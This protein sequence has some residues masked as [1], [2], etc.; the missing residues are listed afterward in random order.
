MQPFISQSFLTYL[1]SSFIIHLHTFHSGHINML[2]FLFIFVL[3]LSFS[4]STYI[5]I[6]IW[7]KFPHLLSFKIH[8]RHHLLLKPCWNSWAVTI[9]AP[10]TPWLSLHHGILHAECCSRKVH[11]TFWRAFNK[12]EIQIRHDFPKVTQ[13]INKRVGTE[14]KVS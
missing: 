2:C 13:L 3:S 8:F 6:C 9:S 1:V 4:L 11:L 5:Y 12:T 7:N 14:I 10:R